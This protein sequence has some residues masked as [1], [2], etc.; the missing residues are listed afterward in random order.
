MS[1]AYLAFSAYPCWG[2]RRDCVQSF[3]P[4]LGVD[5][6]TT[7]EKLSE[8]RFDQVCPTHARQGQ[9]RGPPIPG[10]MLALSALQDRET[11]RK[12][13][14]FRGEG[15][16]DLP[17]AFGAANGYKAAYVAPVRNQTAPRPSARGPARRDRRAS[18]A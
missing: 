2:L 4:S 18:L 16:A 13:A 12:S 10:V 17:H 5:T 15:D 6:L 7:A 9:S 11:G 14:G 1:Q 3:I 8:R